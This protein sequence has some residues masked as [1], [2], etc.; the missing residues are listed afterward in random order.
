MGHVRLSDEQIEAE[1]WSAKDVHEFEDSTLG[2]GEQETATA[3]LEGCREIEA[4][5]IEMVN[6]VLNS[7]PHYNGVS[8]AGKNYGQN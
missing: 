2:S 3:L 7:L 8:K 1:E 4:T 5:A 6:S